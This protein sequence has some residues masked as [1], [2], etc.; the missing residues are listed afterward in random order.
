MKNIW[1]EGYRH[2]MHQSEHEVWNSQHYPG[3]KQLCCNCDRPTGRCEDDAIYVDGEGP[4]C[5]DCKRISISQK[6]GKG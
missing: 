2:A 4:L 1:P 5:M 6:E 3:T